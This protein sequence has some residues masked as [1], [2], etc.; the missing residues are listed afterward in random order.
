MVKFVVKERDR[1]GP[2]FVIDED[3]GIIFELKP[4]AD[5]E[6]ANAFAALLNN[7]VREIKYGD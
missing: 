2:C 3:E 5:F 6:A 4:A 1:D 7:N